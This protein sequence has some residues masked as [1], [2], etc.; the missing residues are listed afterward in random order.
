VRSAT[1]FASAALALTAL[2]FGGVPPAGAAD[3]PNPPVEAKAFRDFFTQKF[4]R[5]KLED[6]VNGPYSINEDMHRQWEEKEQ[7]PPLRVFRRYGKGNVLKA[8]QERQELPPI[9]SRTRASV[10]DRT[11]RTSMTRKARSSRSN[12]R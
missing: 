11:I 1:H 8:L 5:L 12:W 9:A 10:S 7:F 2:A 6:F 3:T 4:P